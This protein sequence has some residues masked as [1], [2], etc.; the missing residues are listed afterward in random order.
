MILARA[1][2]ISGCDWGERIHVQAHHVMSA[3]PTLAFHRAS[4]IP[5]SGPVSQRV[6]KWKLQSFVKEY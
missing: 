6:L 3:G 4:D 1:V 2:V 5:E